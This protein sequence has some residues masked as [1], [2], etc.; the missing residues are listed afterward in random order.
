ML[1]EVSG[2]VQSGIGQLLDMMAEKSWMDVDKCPGFLVRLRKLREEEKKDNPNQVYTWEVRL[3]PADDDKV[4]R[5]PKYSHRLFTRLSRERQSEF[6]Q[7][8]DAYVSY[9][10]LDID[11]CDDVS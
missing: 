7:R 1:I 6:H 3:P 9:D 4:L 5:I 2:E 8:L 11:N 10:E